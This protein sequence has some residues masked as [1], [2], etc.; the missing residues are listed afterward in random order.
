MFL[1][2]SVPLR[3]SNVP[4]PRLAF[5]AQLLSEYLPPAFASHL[6]HSG[7]ADALVAATAAIAKA[8]TRAQP[9][10]P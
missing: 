4:V 5:V 10:D 6:P 2:D 1:G 8:A 9:H 7:N 3:N